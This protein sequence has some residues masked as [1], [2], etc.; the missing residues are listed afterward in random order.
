MLGITEP[1]FGH[2]LVLLFI[3]LFLQPPASGLFMR[4]DAL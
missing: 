4:F 1:Q 3:F 2:Y